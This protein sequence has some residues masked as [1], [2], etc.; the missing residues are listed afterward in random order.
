MS[1]SDNLLKGRIE[2]LKTIDKVTRINL[3][4][5]QQKAIAV[6]PILRALDWDDSRLEEVKFEY[7]VTS[8]NTLGR[9][10]IALFL[11]GRAKLFIEAKPPAPNSLF[12]PHPKTGQTPEDQLLGYCKNG[13][14]NLGV[15]TDG[16]EWWFYAT[17][18]PN[19][20]EMKQCAKI[21]IM[22]SSL[23]EATD[24]LKKFISK[25]A[26]GERS[27]DVLRQNW[28]DKILNNSWNQLLSSAD[29]NIVKTLRR[30]V[31]GPLDKQ[32][33]RAEA[34]N[35]IQSK[36]NPHIGSDENIGRESVPMVRSARNNKQEMPPKMKE[37]LAFLRQE[38]SPT[39]TRVAAVL[40]GSPSGAN[41]ALRRALKK[42]YISK[43][44]Q[45][46]TC[47]YQVLAELDGE[48][49]TRSGSGARAQPRAKRRPTPSSR[50]DVIKVFGEEIEVA[51]WRD[52]VQVFF[53]KAY[54][55]KP[56]EFRAI[57][58]R[59]RRKFAINNARPDS[60]RVPLQI[61]ASDIWVNGS[62]SGERHYATCER[63]RIELNI[64]ESDFICL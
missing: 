62:A 48:G 11:Q 8:G 21:N 28:T 33:P 39:Q 4:E 53:S 63:V 38:P 40:G 34:I 49:Q 23:G 17:V 51:S 30:A 59:E 14:V 64:P 31:K 25:A 41:A 58:E 56:T 1:T 35:F 18:G 3:G 60:I 22:E 16:L 57:A 46:R 52:V 29:A 13:G 6:L 24:T 47:T 19:E 37:L 15:L 2:Y 45:G 54:E 9:V 43:T 42:G 50:P 44:R 61:G 7:S 20:D 5:T 32:L 12:K 55:K 10:D 27:H 26:L 36:A